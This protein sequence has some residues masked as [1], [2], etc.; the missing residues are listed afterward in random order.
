MFLHHIL[1]RLNFSIIPIT[2]WGDPRIL[3]DFIISMT[4][5]GK[6]KYSYVSI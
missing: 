4:L 5:N 6:L 2:L 1:S 3:V